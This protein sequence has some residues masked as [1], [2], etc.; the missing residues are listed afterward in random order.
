MIVV[1]VTICNSCGLVTMI[2]YGQMIK[3]T[4][5]WYFSRGFD[6]KLDHTKIKTQISDSCNIT[7]RAIRLTRKDND[8]IKCYWVDIDTTYYPD[9]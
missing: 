3:P 5:T 7:K 8:T 9:F 6:K 2:L 4:E 1:I